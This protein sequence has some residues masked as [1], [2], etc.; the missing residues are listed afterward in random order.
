MP[1]A[2]LRDDY[3]GYYDTSV[4]GVRLDDDVRAGGTATLAPVVDESV[5]GSNK[6]GP[7]P[8]PLVTVRERFA[9]GYDDDGNP[10]WTWADVISQSSALVFEERTESSDSANMAVE[11]ATVMVL[12]AYGEPPIRES[13]TVLT[14][15]GRR[16]RIKSL[17]RMTDRYQLDLERIDDA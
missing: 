11:T 3:A 16:W 5:P 10:M 9:T 17:K 4:R 6:P 13:A 15:D 2:M 14:S 8:Y 12:Y 1:R 7:N